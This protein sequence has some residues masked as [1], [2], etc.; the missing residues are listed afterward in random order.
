LS[1]FLFRFLL[2][3][4]FDGVML[5]VWYWPIGDKRL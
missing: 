2:L 4:P 5:V 3:L 1:S